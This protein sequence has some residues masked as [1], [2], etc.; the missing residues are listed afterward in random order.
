MDDA[1]ALRAEV[2]RHTKEARTRPLLNLAQRL[3]YDYWAAG[4]G[5]PAAAPVLDELVTVLDEACGYLEA[6]S[7]VRGQVAG[8]LGS[9]LAVRSIVHLSPAHDGDRAVPLLE[10][11]LT[12]PALPHILQVR[13]RQQLATLL[14]TRAMR[15]L[16]DPQA[17]MRLMMPGPPPA[18]ATDADRAVTLLR[19]VRDGPVLGSEIA[20]NAELML[21]MAE[22]VQSLL[23]SGAGSPGGPAGLDLGRMMQAMSRMA[24]LQRK[25]AARPRGAGFGYVPNAFDFAADDLAARPPHERPVM[26]VDEPA[27]AAPASADPA[28]PTP[29][30]PAATYRTAL[31]TLLPSPTATLELLADGASPDIDTLDELVALGSCLVE[32]PGAVPADHLPL[33]VGRYLRGTAGGGE[34]GA[35]GE[36]DDDPDDLK[37]AAAHLLACAETLA[38]QPG[39]DVAVALR[40]ADLV[41]RRAPDHAV[42][43][44]LAE[45]FGPAAAALRTA[46][47]DALVVPTGDGLSVLAAATGRFVPGTVADLPPRVVVIGDLVVPAGIVVSRV[48]SA[49]RLVALA[50]RGR[51]PVT[52][53]AVFVA[54]PR[55]DRPAAGGDALVLRRTFFPRS[56]GLGH[57]VEGCDGAGTP[58]EVVAHLEAS[59]LHLGCGV[60]ADGD[61][62]LA[63]GAVLTIATITAGPGAP[64]G[65]LAVLPPP[66]SAGEGTAALVD[67]LLASRC[68]GVIRFREPVADPVASLVYFLLYT[69]LVDERRDPADAVAAVRRWLADPDRTPPEHLPPW[70]TATLADPDLPGLAARDVLVHHGR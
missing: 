34:W 61:L 8:E 23:G 60:T 33:A 69:R 1:D 5:Q 20:E 44:R 2:A 47:A 70:Y 10:E 3:Q 64:T 59:L 66:R 6:G 51:R 62:E 12:F 24:D 67:A 7:F 17:A 9:V 26:V 49:A 31:V 40:L 55:G 11:S 25:M 16:Q 46:G 4:P 54:D 27:T 30:T 63:D 19:E 37:A 48:D 18:G 13:N 57:T 68:T 42:G 50:A 45:V 39:G 52:E 21:E 35:P 41:D 28:P 15:G 58:D 43:D 36:P 65:G 14:L 56:T 38:T 22:T 29:R 32:A 53:N